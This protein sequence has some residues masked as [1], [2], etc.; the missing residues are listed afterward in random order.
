[1]TELIK[2]LIVKS[3]GRYHCSNCK[4]RIEKEINYFRIAAS[5]NWDFSYILNLCRDCFNGL[6]NWFLNELH[7]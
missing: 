2:S 1:M 4:R 5:N 7:K 6:N 3:N